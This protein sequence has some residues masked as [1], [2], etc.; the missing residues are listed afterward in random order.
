MKRWLRLVT[1]RNKILFILLG[2]I[3]IFS[4]FTIVLT[5]SISEVNEVTYTIKE[6][7][8]PELLWY[9]YWEKEL[10]IKEYMVIHYLQN[11]FEGNFV[12]QYEEN[13]MEMQKENNLIELPSTLENY[14]SR[15]NLLDF[16]I[17]NEVSGLLEYNNVEAAKE[18]INNDYLPELEE[19]RS[20]LIE[21]MELEY[22][23]FT[24]NTN[25]FP[26]IIEKAV[27]L[28][29]IVMVG[30]IILSVYGAY[31]LSKNLTQPLDIMVEKVDDIATG[32]YGEILPATDQKELKT[33]TSSI[34]QMSVRL[35]QSFQTILSDKIKREQ[36]LNSLPV[37][38]ITYDHIQKH[39]NQNLFSKQFF[40]L[41]DEELDKKETNNNIKNFDIF[42]L[43]YSG[44]NFH[45][46]KVKLNWNNKKYVFLVSQT[47]LYDHDHSITGRIFYFVDITEPEELENRMVQSEKLALV[48]EMAA[49]SAHEIRNPLTVIYG[50]ISLLE[51]SLS[52]EEK[53]KFQIPLIMKEIDRLYSIVEQMLLMS[54]QREPKLLPVNI[55]DIFDDLLP[56]LNSSLDAKQIQ[57]KINVADLLVLADSKQL[58]Q[59]FLNLI[60]NSIEAINFDGKIEIYSMIKNNKYYVYFHD[61]GPGI[62][63][64]IQEKL[65]EPF[66]TSKENGTGLGLN[67]VYR[68]LENHEGEIEL[69]NSDGKGTLFVIEL[70]VATKETE[71]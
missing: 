2:I 37:G 45:N 17:V 35:Q 31:R 40:N 57:I 70:S 43:L 26:E 32:N 48:G 71:T 4:C 68:I 69:L 10:D 28:L 24:E 21:D 41:T 9:S 55:N 63:T 61:N 47:N 67:V 59:V 16:I 38:I 1:L 11:D 27:W 19:I 44:E 33:L 22:N 54:H 20:S 30:T 56:L 60:R 42:K 64:E 53:N 14:N 6:D 36:I 49:S 3:F 39:F 25:T 18:V 15:I 8:I 34:N 23:S 52:E 29:I 65:F 7:N 13:E 46:R 12:E 62:P 58:K 51:E 66:A 5:N 50:F